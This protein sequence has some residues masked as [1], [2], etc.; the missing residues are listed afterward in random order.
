MNLSPV[1]YIIIFAAVLIGVLVV[2][3]V[4]QLLC[5][6][7]R[8]IFNKISSISFAE[9]KAKISF[10]NRRKGDRR[11]T[12]RRSFDRGFYLRK[13]FFDKDLPPEEF[14]DEDYI[15]RRKDDRRKDDR[16]F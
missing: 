14:G 5:L 15:D 9:K 12:D 13:G 10:S 2:Y 16:R 11:G 4:I 6:F 7:F 3:K 1:E 8:M